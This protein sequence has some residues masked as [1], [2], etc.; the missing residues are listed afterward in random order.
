MVGLIVAVAVTFL[1]T[2]TLDRAG[3]VKKYLR[4]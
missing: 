2:L 4:I 1:V 3:L